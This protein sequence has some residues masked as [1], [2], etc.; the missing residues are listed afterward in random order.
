MLLVIESNE[1]G[2]CGDV[3]NP[4]FLIVVSKRVVSVSYAINFKI[5]SSEIEFGIN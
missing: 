4:Q 1:T 3:S 5:P 2:Y